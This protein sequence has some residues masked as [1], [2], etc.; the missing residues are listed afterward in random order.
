MQT[1]KLLLA[2]LCANAPA[3]AGE[4]AQ[5]AK[6][7]TFEYHFAT[8]RGA[9]LQP[10]GGVQASSGLQAS[11]GVQRAMGLQPSAGQRGAGP[12]VTTPTS[13]EE[14]RRMFPKKAGQK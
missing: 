2:F 13:E 11:G 5:P 3:M 1:T 12:A 14:W 4:E 6:R 8:L 9:T 10:S 7:K